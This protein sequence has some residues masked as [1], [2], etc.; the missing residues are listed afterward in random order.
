MKKNSSPTQNLA[1]PY[2]IVHVADNDG[3][4]KRANQKVSN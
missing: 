1:G 4:N 2:F 3:F